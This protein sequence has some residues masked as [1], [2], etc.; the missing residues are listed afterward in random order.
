MDK[1]RDINEM[2]KNLTRFQVRKLLGNPSMIKGNLSPRIDQVYHYHGDLNAD[3][4]EEK[5]TVNFYRDR[6]V[7]FTS[8]FE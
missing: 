4:E 5:G 7:S 1:T 6:V 2:K 8:P 3:G